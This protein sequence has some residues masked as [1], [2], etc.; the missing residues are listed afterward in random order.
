MHK[1]SIRFSILLVIMTLFVGFGVSFV[2]PKPV[3]ADALG[4][5]VAR[6]SLGDF[7]RNF[8]QAILGGGRDPE[9]M[10]PEP[11]Y[12]DP[13]YPTAVPTTQPVPNPTETG[14]YT[15]IC[16]VN[17]HTVRKWSFDGTTNIANLE[18]PV[19]NLCNANEKHLGLSDVMALATLCINPQQLSP[20]PTMTVGGAC[21]YNV[22]LISSSGTP[23]RSA[24]QTGTYVDNG[25][26]TSG[27]SEFVPSFYNQSSPLFDQPQWPCTDAMY[28]GQECQ[29]VVGGKQIC[30][31]GPLHEIRGCYNP[32]T[33]IYKK[34]SITELTPTP[35]PTVPVGATA[36]PTQSLTPAATNTPAPTPLPQYSSFPAWF[37]AF[38]QNINTPSALNAVTLTILE[39]WRN[40][41]P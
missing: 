23:E 18:C 31:G 13:P 28:V 32:S 12:P 19:N 37:G 15:Y 11:P 17:R 10:Y 9:P 40:N 33:Q 8:F 20:T 39:D 41:T 35:T 25:C 3:R 26:R 4:E 22:R 38:T 6:L 5:F 21:Y 34:L 14:T 27:V 16:S 29:E 7:I 2:A 24:I 36:T 1:R 30:I